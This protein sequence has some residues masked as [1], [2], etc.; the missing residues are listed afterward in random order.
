MEKNMKRF[1]LEINYSFYGEEEQEELEEMLEAIIDKCM[2]YSSV[3]KVE[4]L[5]IGYKE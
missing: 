1:Y 3:K 2:D 5:P 4:I